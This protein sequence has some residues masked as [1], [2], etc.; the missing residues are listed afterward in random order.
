MKPI[1]QY[2]YKW[3]YRD[4]ERPEGYCYDCRMK[5][6]EFPD[7]MIPDE[8]WEKINP[9]YHEGAGLLCPTCIANRLNFLGLWYEPELFNL[10]GDV[11]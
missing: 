2:R 9:T 5:Y 11:R 1:D 8:L 4:E 3:K 7:F 6:N 10:K